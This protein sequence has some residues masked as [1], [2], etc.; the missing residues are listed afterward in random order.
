M[1][2]PVY[3]E[4]PEKNYWAIYDT[5]DK[6]QFPIEIANLHGYTYPHVTRVIKSNYRFGTPLQQ[7]DLIINM[8]PANGINDDNVDTQTDKYHNKQQQL[9]HDIMAIQYHDRVVFVFKRDPQSKNEKTAESTI[10]TISRTRRVGPSGPYGGKT[11][12]RHKP[13]H[14]IRKPSRKTARRK[15]LRSVKKPSPK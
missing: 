15:S 12:K 8:Y 4:L 7:G 10:F 11:M 9:I 5:S 3:P 6:Q 13:R 14:A 2:G 1:S